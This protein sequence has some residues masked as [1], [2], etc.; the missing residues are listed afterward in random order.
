[1]SIISGFDFSTI[2][3]ACSMESR[4]A[5][6]ICIPTGRSFSYMSSLI[7][8]FAASLIRPSEEINS[9]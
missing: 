9:V 8:L 4:F 1:M 7:T 6:N 5:P 2:S 3:T